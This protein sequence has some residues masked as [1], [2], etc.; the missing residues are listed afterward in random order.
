MNRCISF[1]TCLSSISGNVTYFVSSSTPFLGKKYLSVVEEAASSFAFCH[2]SINLITEVALSAPTSFSNFSFISPI[3]SAWF[4][5]LLST[6][7]A[8]GV[9]SFP[10]LAVLGFLFDASSI[11]SL[12]PWCSSR[13]RFL[14]SMVLLLDSEV[15]SPLLISIAMSF[16]LGVG[17]F[18][19]FS[20]EHRRA[21]FPLTSTSRT[22]K[23][24]NLP[25][26]IAANPA[27]SFDA[28]AVIP[29]F[30]SISSCLTF[31]MSSVSY[32]Y[33]VLALFDESMST[34]ISLQYD[35]M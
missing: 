27:T 2:F 28:Y 3:S 5:L 25:F 35:S 17:G 15:S 31:V 12:S 20:R 22:Q 9:S 7:A 26:K 14:T 30:S 6:T 1:L 4:G 19:L 32:V 33:Y 18:K 13:L 29:N 10:S 34:K 21:T 23:S 24:E 8:A 16:V 11:C